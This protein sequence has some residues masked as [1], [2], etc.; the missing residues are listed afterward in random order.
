MHF[1]PNIL[2]TYDGL[3]GHNFIVSQ[4]AMCLELPKA[5]GAQGRDR[6]KDPKRGYGKDEQG[7]D[8]GTGQSGQPVQREWHRG[9]EVQSLCK[10]NK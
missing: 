1:Q 7:L 6:G 4:G 9:R 3:S 8:L 2:P 5:V 10:S